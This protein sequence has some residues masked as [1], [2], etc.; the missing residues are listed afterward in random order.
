MM[1]SE[2]RAVK[3]PAEEMQ[4]RG[5]QE[6]ERLGLTDLSAVTLSSP[7]KSCPKCGGK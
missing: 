7:P 1:L 3:P 2:K 4:S 6:E 5:D